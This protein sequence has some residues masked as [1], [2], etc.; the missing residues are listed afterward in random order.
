[1][2]MGLV[3]LLSGG[4]GNIFKKTWDFTPDT[5]KKLFIVCSIFIAILTRQI[6]EHDSI[7]TLSI[8]GEICVS[9]TFMKESFPPQKVKKLVRKSNDLGP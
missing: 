1:M 5:E 7:H 9:P 4:M 6:H 3:F 2:T 8:H